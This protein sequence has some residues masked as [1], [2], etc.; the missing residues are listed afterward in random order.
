M[1]SVIVNRSLIL[2]VTCQHL[3][4]HRILISCF[5]LLSLS[6]CQLQTVTHNPDRAASDANR[7]LKVLYLEQNYVAAIEVADIQ[8]RQSVTAVDLQHL[9]QGIREKRGELKV[10]KADS[11]LMTPGRTMELF[12]TGIYERGTLYHRIVLQGE[13]TSGYRVSGVWYQF[14]PYPEQT[15]RRKFE[16]DI[17]VARFNPG[18]AGGVSLSLTHRYYDPA[19]GHFLTRDP[20]SYVTAQV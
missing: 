10:L 11:Y 6:G 16:T 5:G 12:Y 7:F 9:V 14:D 1:Y 8:L 17:P 20:I 18:T 15:L 2:I 3:S 13:A 4:R 19:T